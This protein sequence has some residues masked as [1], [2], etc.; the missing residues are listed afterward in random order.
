M[1]NVMINSYVQVVSHEQRLR[2]KLKQ[3]VDEYNSIGWTI[4]GLA[5]LALL[6]F[7]VLVAASIWCKN[8]GFHGGAA[9]DWDRGNIFQVGVSCRR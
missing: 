7:I 6:A 5:A 1:E 8:R 2:E 4:V 3:S 9:V